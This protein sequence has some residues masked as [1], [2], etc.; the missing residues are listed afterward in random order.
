[1]EEER[2]PKKS[3]YKKFQKTLYVPARGRVFNP[4]RGYPRNKPCFCGS[5][6][7]FKKC[8]LQKMPDT[9]TKEEDKK[10]REAGVYQFFIK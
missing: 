2:K 1:M 5:K 3:E 4:L 10:L 6:K 9:I 7:K 8:C